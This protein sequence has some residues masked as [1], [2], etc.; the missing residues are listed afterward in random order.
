MTEWEF[1]RKLR[2]IKDEIKQALKELAEAR[3]H[4]I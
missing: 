2:R 3:I 4:G 1:L